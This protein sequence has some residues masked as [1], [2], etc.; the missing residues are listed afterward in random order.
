MADIIVDFAPCFRYSD[1]ATGDIVTKGP[2]QDYVKRIAVQVCS[3]ISTIKMQQDIN[4]SFGHRISTLENKS[5]PTLTIPSLFPTCIADVNT[6]LPLDEFTQLLELKVCEIISANGTNTAIFNAI[7]T[8]PSDFNNSKALGTSGGIMGALQ[9]WVLDPKNIADSVINIWKT[10]GDLRSAVR[11][12]QIN[13][14]SSSCAGVGVT[15]TATLQNKILKLFFMGT[16]PENLGSCFPGGSTF[17]ISDESGNWFNSVIDIKGNLNNSSGVSIDLSSTAINFADDLDVHTLMCFSD[18]ETGTTCQ[19]CLETHVD[20]NSNCPVI[21]VVAG[22]TS[23]T[24]SFVHVTGTLTYSIQLFDSTNTMV[25]SLN[26]SASSPI[27]ISG[28]FSGLV[29][30]SAYRVRVQMIT[31]ANTKTCPFIPFNTLPN[32]CAAPTGISVTIVY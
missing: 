27:T 10:L 11:N 13:C 6:L 14:C 30:A 22:L 21:S 24:Y 1:P 2:I 7:N 8:P 31:S 5:T 16:V 15:L 32:P 9:G 19:S 17:K 12:I 25:Q 23:V 20:N 28:T 3:L 29:V 4:T 26:V 18:A